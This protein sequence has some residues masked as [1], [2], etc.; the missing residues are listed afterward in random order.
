MDINGLY[1]ELQ[2]WLVYG[3]R[4]LWLEAERNGTWVRIPMRR[5]MSGFIPPRDSEEL[6]IQAQ[7]LKEMVDELHHHNT[8]IDMRMTDAYTEEL[9]RYVHL[10][11]HRSY[12][13]S[14]LLIKFFDRVQSPIMMGS[15][16]V[17][18]EPISQR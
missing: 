11:M 14:M 5:S 12:L 10:P 3:S 13:R 17:F 2:P 4:L 9:F 8:D 1:P 18:P 16:T 6:W 7:N 15:I